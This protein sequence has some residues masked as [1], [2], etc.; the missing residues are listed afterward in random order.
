MGGTNTSFVGGEVNGAEELLAATGEARVAADNIDV[1]GGVTVEGTAWPCD[2]I[3]AG[4]VGTSATSSVCL[5][6]HASRGAANL[7]NLVASMEAANSAALVA[8]A[9]PIASVPTGIPNSLLILYITNQRPPTCVSLLL[10]PF[11][12]ALLYLQSIPAGICTID[13]RLSMPL[14]VRD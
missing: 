4:V 9:F 3:A 5:R 8:P 12:P 7:G 11:P 13:K 10:T 14:N 1:T 6:R 2:A